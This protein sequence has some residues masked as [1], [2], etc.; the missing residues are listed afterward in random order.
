[1]KWLKVGLLI[2]TT[3]DL[4]DNQVSVEMIGEK[5]QYF[6][7]VVNNLYEGGG[8]LVKGNSFIEGIFSKGHLMYGWI[9]KQNGSV[10]EGYFLNN[11]L[12]GKGTRKCNLYSCTGRFLNNIPHGKCH[13]IEYLSKDSFT[14]TSDGM[15]DGKR[16]LWAFG[17]YGKMN[18]GKIGEFGAK[19]DYQ[20]DT[21]YIGSFVDGKMCG[22]GKLSNNKNMNTYEGD[23]FNDMY[24][25]E[26][27]FKNNSS[28]FKGT[29]KNG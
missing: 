29:F 3:L 25:G 18:N 16:G 14:S 21:T 19:L 12:N 8:M 27:I 20:K 5:E 24:N 2:P 13:Y 28:T 1:M 23:F 10:L 7:G 11:C 17:F 22:K 15:K 9:T 6:G 26:G 4:D